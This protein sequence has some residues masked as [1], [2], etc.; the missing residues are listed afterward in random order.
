MPETLSRT[1]LTTRLDA[2]ARDVVEPTRV[3]I[4]A[5]HIPT[6][7]RH[8]RLGGAALLDRIYTQA[9]LAFCA[10]RTDRLSTRFAGKE[11][12]L[13]ALGTGIRGV[14]LRDVEIVSEPG[15]RPTVELN[16]PAA[17]RAAE[18]G[19]CRVDVSLC[20]EGPFALAVAAALSEAGNE[21]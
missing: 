3:G 9:E 15:G 17:A 16:G 1:P 21:R 14:G 18:I 10:S 4:D 7:E 20:H 5:V 19:V 8:L 6:W 12:V 13:K 2:L 11:T